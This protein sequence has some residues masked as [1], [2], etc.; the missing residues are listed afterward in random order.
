MT[1]LEKETLDAC[2]KLI[3]QLR[4]MKICGHHKGKRIASYQ[5]LLKVTD[6]KDRLNNWEAINGEGEA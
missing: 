3:E 2:E 4:R 6:Y 5:L 1:G